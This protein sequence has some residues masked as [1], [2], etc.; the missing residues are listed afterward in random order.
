MN[1]KADKLDRLMWLE[2][3]GRWCSRFPVVQ[4]P[5]SI[6]AAPLQSLTIT[7]HSSIKDTELVSQ[8]NS[9]YS[10]RLSDFIDSTKIMIYSEQHAR[11]NGSDPRH[12]RF[13]LPQP[14]CLSHEAVHQIA[15]IPVLSAIRKLRVADLISM[16]MIEA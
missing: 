8:S 4:C 3:Y 11:L 1:E 6:L 13:Q 10:V 5:S 15:G 16:S 14:L 9:L 2:L 7:R 12:C